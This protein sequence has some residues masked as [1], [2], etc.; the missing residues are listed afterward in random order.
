M[1]PA[2]AEIA[3]ATQSAPIRRLPLPAL[4]AGLA[5]LLAAAGYASLALGY[6]VYSAGEI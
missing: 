5:V 3:V 6:K 1:G 4:Y 2:L